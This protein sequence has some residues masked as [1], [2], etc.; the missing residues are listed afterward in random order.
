MFYGN[1]TLLNTVSLPDLG[2]L[3]SLPGTFLTHVS[4]K[5]SSEMS[6]NKENESLFITQCFTNI[7]EGKKITTNAFSN[8]TNSF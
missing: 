5:N 7:F 4:M 1:G 8:Y 2:S 3:W 6:R